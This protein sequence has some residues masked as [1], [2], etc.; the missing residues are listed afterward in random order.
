MKASR[1]LIEEWMLLLEAGRVEFH[2]RL[3]V[4]ANLVNPSF[5]YNPLYSP[6]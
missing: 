2:A 4:S 3:L 5:G 1:S 6:C